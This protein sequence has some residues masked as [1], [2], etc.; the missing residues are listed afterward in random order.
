[1]HKTQLYLEESQYLIL[2]DWAVKRKKSI[3]QLVR[4]MIDLAIAPKQGADP[5]FDVIG[6]APSKQ[7]NVSRHV[8]DYLYGDD[9]TIRRLEKDGLV[10]DR[11]PKR[12]KK[13]VT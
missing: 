5:I 2:R 8:D 9:E 10:R 3:A 4:E 7:S 11:T 12:K 13:R 1:M 6:I